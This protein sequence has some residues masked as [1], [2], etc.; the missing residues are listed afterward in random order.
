MPR[1]RKVPKTKRLSAWKAKQEVER[2]ADQQEAEITDQEP[3]VEQEVEVREEELSDEQEVEVTGQGPAVEQEVEVTGAWEGQ[4]G[5]FMFNPLTADD[6]MHLAGQLNL[7]VA[8]PHNMK[9]RNVPLEPP[10][11]LVKIDKDGNC[12]YRAISH[13]ICGTQMYHHV[14]RQ[15]LIHFMSTLSEDVYRSWFDGGLTMDQYLARADW[16]HNGKRPGDFRAWATEG[17]A[18]TWLEDPAQSIQQMGPLLGKEAELGP[19]ETDRGGTSHQQKDTAHS[20]CMVYNFVNNCIYKS[21]K[22]SQISIIY[23]VA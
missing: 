2:L 7:P 10:R 20:I 22:A 21:C 15:H 12:F 14:V 3:A 8:K 9:Q 5:Q 16:A 4:D 17:Q 23:V 6:Q 13:H 19:G 18:V 11:D 1:R